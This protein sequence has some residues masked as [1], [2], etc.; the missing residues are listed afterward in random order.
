MS[1]LTNRAGFAPVV[2]A[3]VNFAYLYQ[4]KQQAQA[5]PATQTIN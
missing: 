5:T 3:P 1:D 2:L 4:Q